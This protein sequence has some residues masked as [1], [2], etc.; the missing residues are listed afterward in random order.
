MPAF[1]FVLVFSLM[2]VEA[3]RAG[4]NERAQRARGGVEPDGDVYALMRVLYPAAFAAMIAEGVLGGT[5]PARE[6]FAAGLVVFVIA[7]ALKWWAIV[8][9]GP[10][11]TFRVIVLPGTA[12]VS[13]GP[14][15]F[16][17]HPNYVG[18]VGELVGVA[19]MTRAVVAG[20]IAIV[21]FGALLLKRIS[22]E[23]RALRCAR[24]KA[25][26]AILR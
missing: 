25:P 7:K 5:P 10:L 18:V 2:L 6:L 15:R 21:A 9:L 8:S 19:L 3:A 13:R 20:P 22:V 4:R 26:D 14:Y 12:L 11:W 24:G 23:A 17:S 1:I 16:L